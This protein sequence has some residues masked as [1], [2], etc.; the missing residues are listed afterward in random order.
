MEQVCMWGGGARMCVH[1]RVCAPACACMH[2]LVLSKSYW[3]WRE[4]ASSVPPPTPSA[5][6]HQSTLLTKQVPYRSYNLKDNVALLVHL[7]PTHTLA[8]PGSAGQQQ[9]QQQPQQQQPEQPQQPQQQLQQPP[10]AGAQQQGGVL[11]ANTHILFNTKRGD[12]KLGQL[13]TVLHR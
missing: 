7:Q 8:R 9:P 3:T 12:V 11:V 13:R 2:V 1:V 5:C 4:W 6:T 10:Q